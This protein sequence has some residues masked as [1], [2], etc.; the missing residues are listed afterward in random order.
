MNGDLYISRNLTGIR[1]SLE[2]SHAPGM[3]IPASC[4]LLLLLSC[5]KCGTFGT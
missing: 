1:L 2:T 5:K 4:L 3:Q